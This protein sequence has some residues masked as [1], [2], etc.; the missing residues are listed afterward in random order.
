MNGRFHY[1]SAGRG[2]PAELPAAVRRS[3][4][5]GKPEDAAELSVR[6]V[7]VGDLK[8]CRKLRI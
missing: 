5:A 4:M 7:H 8:L 3:G 2:G 1:K 6:S